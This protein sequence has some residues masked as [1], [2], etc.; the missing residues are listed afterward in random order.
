MYVSEFDGSIRVLGQDLN[1]SAENLSSYLDDPDYTSV[2][3]EVSTL[4]NNV[5]VNS[6]SFVIDTDNNFYLITT[7]VKL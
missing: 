1:V 5:V 2:M 7:I 6:S 4:R 3:G